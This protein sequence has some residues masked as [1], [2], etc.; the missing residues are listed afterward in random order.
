MEKNN[1]HR[2]NVLKTRHCKLFALHSQLYGAH[3]YIHSLRMESASFVI[4][5]FLLTALEG[6]REFHL[7]PEPQL[8]NAESTRKM[9][10][11]EVTSHSPEDH[12]GESPAELALW[13]RIQSVDSDESEY[14]ILESQDFDNTFSSLPAAAKAWCFLLWMFGSNQ[15][16]PDTL[17]LQLLTCLY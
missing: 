17:S 6:H 16:L 13:I 11:W 8:R 3:V 5:L 2:R 9:E 1:W 14:R 15:S 12:T 10:R 4:T 7:Q